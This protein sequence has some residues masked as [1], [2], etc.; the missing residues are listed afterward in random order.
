LQ[1]D[2][3]GR[4]IAEGEVVTACQAACP[5]RA[6]SFG[7]LSDPASAVAQVKRS[8]RGYT[9]LEELN[10]RPRTTYLARVSNP[11]PQAAHE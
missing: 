1:A 9:L 6:I 2:K 10:T 8:P 5:T 3:E 11:N 7:D 4:R